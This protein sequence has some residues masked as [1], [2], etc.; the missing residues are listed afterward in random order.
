ML[1]FNITDKIKIFYWF[2]MKGVI[3][4]TLPALLWEKWENED[5]HFCDVIKENLFDLYDDHDFL[6]TFMLHPSD[7]DKRCIHI[8]YVQFT[9]GN[10][11]S[12]PLINLINICKQL[13]Q[14]H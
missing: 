2:I 13:K 7:E 5:Q 4:I 9:I 14:K 8:G 11:E 10:V 3:S 1:I 6:L 12:N